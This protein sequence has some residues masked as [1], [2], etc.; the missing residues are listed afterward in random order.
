MTADQNLG[1]RLHAVGRRLR[2][3]GG[4]VLVI[5][6]VA[7]IWI[8]IDAGRESTDD[9]QVDGHIT[10]IAGRIGGTVE[11]VNV[12]DNQQVEAGAVLVQLDRRTYQAIVDRATAELADAEAAAR[13]AQAGVPIVS[14]TTT[15]G[16]TTAEAGVGE[17]RAAVQAAMTEIDAA[18]ARLAAAQARLREREAE[19][20]RAQRDFERLAELI[21]KD[22]IS[23][24]QYDAARTAAESLRASRAVTEADI[25]AA[26][27]AVRVAESRLAQARGAQIRAESSLLN[28]HTAPEQLVATRAQAAAAAAR[29]ERAR[30]LLRQAQ[31]DLE[32]TAIRAPSRGVVSKKSVEIGQ[33]I[34][35]GQPLMALVSMDEVWVTANF[36]ETQL[37]NMR[38]GQR[39]V[40]TVDAYGGRRFDGTIDSIASATGARFSVLPAENATGNYVKVVQRVPVKIVLA[41]GQDPARPLR[42]GMSVVPTVYTRQH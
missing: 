22:E 27:S 28:A 18:R 12:T 8:Y 15:S 21:K 2:T 14:T 10:Q 33:V 20:T 36:K 25:T 7:A 3:I 1:H 35:P 39:V 9:A 26:E 17:A 24:Q 31:L 41:S 38:P 19:A 29:V 23:Q 40:F 11:A 30:A 16:V 4:A 6:A 5:V 13:A 37:A 34:Q 32:H 42:P